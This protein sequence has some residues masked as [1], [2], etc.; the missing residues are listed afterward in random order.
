MVFVPFCSQ[1]PPFRSRFFVRLS[2]AARGAARAAVA[3]GGDATPH[4]RPQD[5][6]FILE[7]STTVGVGGVYLPSGNLT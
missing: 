4:G 3:D 5:V 6:V 7:A 2:R 1:A